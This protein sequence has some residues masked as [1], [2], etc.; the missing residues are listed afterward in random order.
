M[1]AVREAERR[2]HAQVARLEEQAS[3]L[4]KANEALRAEIAECRRVCDVL[5]ESEQKLR[6]VIENTG[7]GVVLTDERGSIVE[8]N[9]AEEQITG[10]RR[11]ETLGRPLW[12]VQLQ[13]AA[14]G[15]K[16]PAAYERIRDATLHA[17]RTGQASMPA[18]SGEREIRRPDDELRIAQALP[19]I[20]K[21]DRGFML[22]AISRDVTERRRAEEALRESEARFRDLVETTSDWVWEV[23]AEG[24]YTYTSPQV[25]NLLGYEPEEVLGRTPFELMPPGEAQR[26]RGIFRTAVAQQRPLSSLENTNLH[27]D[28]WPVILETS[29]V[30]FYDA[31][32]RLAGYRGIDRDITARKRAE[33]ALR[34]LAEASSVLVSSLDYP[35]VLESVARLAVPTLADWSV[36]DILGA[37]PPIVA[38]GVAH[39]GPAKV[40]R[41]RDL[42]RRYPLSLNQLQPFRSQ[43]LAG[44]PV[45]IAEVTDELLAAVARDAEHLRLM[46]ELEIRSIMIVPLLVRDQ[47]LGALLLVSTRADRRYGPMDLTLAQELARRAAQA[48]DNARLYQEAEES[49]RQAETLMEEAQRRAA[50][51]DTTIAAIPDGL[52]I[53]GAAG[54]ILRMNEAAARMVGLAVADRAK[55]F[56]EHLAMLP[57]ETPE[58]QPF[59]PDRLPMAQALHGKT[60]RGVVLVPQRPDGAKT[61]VSASAAPIRAADG[62]LLGAVATFTDITPLHELQ[63]RREDLLRAVSHDLRSPLTAILGQAELLLRA[64][65]RA[66]MAGRERRNAEGIIT[67]ARRMNAMIQDLV[68]SARLEAGQIRLRPMPLDLRTF[69][70]NLKERLA[71]ELETGRIVVE[72]PADLPQVRADPDRLERILTNLLSNALKY[73]TPGTPVV[74]TLTPRNGEVETAVADRG[75][76]IAPEELPHLFSRYYRA[77][78]RREGKEGLGLGLYIAKGLVEA[79]GGRIG[80]ASEPG[81]GSTF[82]FTLPVA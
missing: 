28:G 50:E 14:E 8:W 1:P 66:G 59:P 4:A 52:I 62:R 60:V 78:A 16:S 58:G 30:P 18:W 33:E 17:L 54:E 82:S 68:D 5:R 56:A 12:D 73:S 64:L 61:W 34:F 81:V 20:V 27:K 70:Y 47:L 65:D 67:S 48:V 29:G 3:E 46:R 25:R 43:L 32:G 10:L 44:Q 63:E 57:I 55:P 35:A 37:P 74:V 36:V 31:Q 23:D 24:V 49:R 6:S 40:A 76:G 80:V 38:A 15:E 22:G 71:D 42:Q 77:R 11:D 41:V 75:P 13:A 21:T 72:A 9:R 26:V 45:L 69:A 79:H 7:D 39:V 53:Y 51:L 19:F 2:A